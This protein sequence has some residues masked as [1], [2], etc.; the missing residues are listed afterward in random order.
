MKKTII[1]KRWIFFVLLFFIPILLGF[2][3]LGEI[4]IIRNGILDLIRT[5]ITPR[6]R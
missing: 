3:T 4:W 2:M 1:N 6:L 5:K